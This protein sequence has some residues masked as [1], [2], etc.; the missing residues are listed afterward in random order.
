M[1][2]EEQLRE[3]RENSNDIKQLSQDKRLF[4][5]TTCFVMTTTTTTTLLP[6]ATAYKQNRGKYVK[7]E[8]QT[9]RALISSTTM[10]KTTTL[11]QIVN[12]DCLRQE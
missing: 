7:L 2:H 9:C 4:S 3:L 6:V 1:H 12:S 10:M 5:S 8:Q 11:E